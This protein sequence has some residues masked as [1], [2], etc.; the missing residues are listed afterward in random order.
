MNGL[1]GIW[2]LVSV[3]FLFVCLFSYKTKI[4][5]YHQVIITENGTFY[6][7]RNYARKKK[8]VFLFIYF[9]TQTVYCQS[10]HIHNTAFQ[11]P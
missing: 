5:T 6:T 10:K 4:K 11:K 9:L 1:Q 2:K 8:P 3:I 7:F